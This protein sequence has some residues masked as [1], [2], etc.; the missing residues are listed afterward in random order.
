MMRTA[1]GRETIRQILIG[2]Y[3][4][5]GVQ[6]ELERQHAV[7]VQAVHCESEL[8]QRLSQELIDLFRGVDA[9][10]DALT[11]DSRSLA[12]RT[13][14]VEAYGHRC[15]VCRARILT[16]V[17]R[18]AVQAAHIVPF[19]VCHNN[20]PRNGLALCPLHHWA[21]DQGMLTVNVQHRVLIHAFADERT[22]DE[23]FLGL[24]GKEIQHPQ[25]HRMQPAPAALGWH[26]AHVYDKAG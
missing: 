2:T 22:A 23:Q 24:K 26:R 3:F 9:L 7:N 5:G 19:S 6:Q 12:F 16:P 21:F 8:R 25:D 17:G 18:S 14:I 1:E 11:E 13:L 15:A 10:D 4:S 20:D